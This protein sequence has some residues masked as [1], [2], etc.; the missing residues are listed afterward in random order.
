MAN[1]Y[2]PFNILQESF[3]QRGGELYWKQRPRSHFKTER[4]MR[5]FNSKY[6]GEIAGTLLGP[7]NLYK[8]VWIT[9][10]AVKYQVLAH[11]V[12]WALYYGE[13]PESSIDHADGNGLNNEPANLK[14]ASQTQNMHNKRMYRNNR[15]GHTGVK[16]HPDGT[17]W[18][19]F[20]TH[21]GS[22][23]TIGSF[24][25]LED[26]IFARKQWEAGKGLSQRHGK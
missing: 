1:L 9:H 14:L 17:R 21:E 3:A 12:V 10:Q 13:Y 11:V 8:I 19:A 20:G 23:K 18:I 26:A 22:K 15:S 4:G 2:L 25:K 7:K 6:P 16:Q 24:D 5:V